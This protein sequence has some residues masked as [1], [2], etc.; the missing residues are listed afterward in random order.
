MGLQYLSRAMFRS[1]LLARHVY[2]PPGSC[3]SAR[4]REAG[5]PL[6]WV[7]GAWAYHQHHPARS[8]AREHA[9]R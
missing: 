6:R 5:V 9:T 1:A 4:A 8:P 2:A 7:G 3:V